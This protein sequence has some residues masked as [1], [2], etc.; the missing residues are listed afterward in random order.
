MLYRPLGK[1]GLQVSVLSFGA[2]VTFGKQIGD[3]VAKKLLHSAY[4]ASTT[5]KPTPTARPRS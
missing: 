3:P 4:D 5:P 1:S 2:W